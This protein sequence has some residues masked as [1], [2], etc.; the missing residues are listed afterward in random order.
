MAALPAGVAKAL[1]LPWAERRAES[2]FSLHQH[3]K[4]GPAGATRFG[5]IFVSRL[6][7]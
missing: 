6:M 4:F 2:A 7:S 3:L 1:M 5:G